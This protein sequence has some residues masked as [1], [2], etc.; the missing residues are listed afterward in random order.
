MN[1]DFPIKMNP[2]HIQFALK[3]GKN[4]LCVGN[5]GTG[6]TSMVRAELESAGVKYLYLS[7]STLDPWTDLVGV[8][9]KSEG[10]NPHLEFVRRKEFVEGVDAIVI[11][12]I[13]RYSHKKVVDALMEIIQFGTINGEKLGDKKPV[14]F[15][16]AN[17]P[18]AYKVND[19]DCALLDRFPI[20]LSSSNNPNAEYFKDRYGETG[21]KLI[22]WWNGESEGVRRLVSP[23]L[24]DELGD[25]VRLAGVTAAR[26]VLPR[27]ANTIRLHNLLNGAETPNFNALYR[28]GN[29]DA[30]RTALYADGKNNL[31]ALEKEWELTPDSDFIV[32]T[33][34]MLEDEDFA[35]RMSTEPLAS[36]LLNNANGLSVKK[37][38]S[39]FFL[40]RSQFVK[41]FN[42]KLATSPFAY[43]PTGKD[44]AKYVGKSADEL[45]YGI[46]HNEV[47]AG[48]ETHI[49]TCIAA[50][51]SSARPDYHINFKKAARALEDRA[52]DACNEA[53]YDELRHILKDV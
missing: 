30:I 44:L 7:A 35:A 3:N 45:L 34:F 47:E 50:N 6:K 1:Y 43:N 13:N 52:L 36:I 22:E 8:P 53:L 4:L 40:T 14:V 24:L 41:N 17:P 39:A 51:Y 28:N 10:A 31:A 48:N 32:Q 23:R 37:R 5:H 15:A 26:W 20:K 29:K 9:F 38:M 49:A 11:D 21:Y 25:I 12:E 18:G 33:A 16:M 42:A 27:E 2:S 19:L 46:S